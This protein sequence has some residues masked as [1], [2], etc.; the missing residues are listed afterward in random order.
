MVE[1]PKTQ[2]EIIMNLWAFIQLYRHPSGNFPL[3]Y[4][5]GIRLYA[6]TGSDE[7]K[8]AMLGKL[9]TWDFHLA[10]IF[11]VP[12]SRS[13]HLGLGPIS[14]I[15][16]PTLKGVVPPQKISNLEQQMALFGDAMEAA[17]QLLP[18][19]T[20]TAGFKHTPL[21]DLSLLYTFT[22]VDVGEDGKMTARTRVPELTMGD[23]NVAL[24]LWAFQDSESRLV[25]TLAGRAYL[26]TGNRIEAE[27]VLANLAVADH[28]LLNRIEMPTPIP[29]TENGESISH[30]K[31]FTTFKMHEEAMFSLVENHILKEI[32]L[33]HID[34]EKKMTHQYTLPA[35]GRIRNA[36]VVWADDSGGTAAM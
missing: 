10:S 11:P 22:P 1:I 35:N 34:C 3:I 30:P 8:L 33:K 13:V 32:P 36:T 5:L 15:S 28:F 17:R 26:A 19:N 6:A 21:E 7:N 27:A 12:E 16:V 29:I 24:N 18:E 2:P 9:A 14:E 4:Q 31:D 25:Q 23:P 20:L